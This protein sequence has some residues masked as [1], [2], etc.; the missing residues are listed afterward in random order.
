MNSFAIV[1]LGVGGGLQV[2]GGYPGWPQALAAIAKQPNAE[3]YL[4]GQCYGPATIPQS[5]SLSPQDLSGS[6]WVAVLTTSGGG[7]TAMILYGTFQSFADAQAWI[8]AQPFPANFIAAK[9][10][11]LS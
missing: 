9:V 2:F 6:P 3:S 8:L 5:Q 4:V 1:Y 7:N 11:S 10:T